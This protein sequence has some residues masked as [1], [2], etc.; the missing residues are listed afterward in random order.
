[1]NPEY[2]PRR[3]FLKIRELAGEMPIDEIAAMVKL[4]TQTVA[5]VIAG[6]RQPS[7]IAVDDDHPLHDEM[8]T[9][10]RC[11]GCGALVFTWPCLGC[12]MSGLAP[13]S[14]ESRIAGE[15]LKYKRQRI[16]R[17]QQGLPPPQR[18]AA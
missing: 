9:A 5:E 4:S 14:A 3:S 18:G 10:T 6:R 15:P 8:L 1:M 12:Q 11:A 17:R 16:R 2:L 13:R 7:R